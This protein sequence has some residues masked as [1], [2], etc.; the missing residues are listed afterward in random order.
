[1]ET[2]ILL[3]LFF[4]SVGFPLFERVLMIQSFQSV[5][6]L[7]LHCDELKFH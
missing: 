7:R 5:N 6:P 2:F 4:L 1:M 3:V